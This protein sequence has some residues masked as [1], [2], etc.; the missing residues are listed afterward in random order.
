MDV[1]LPHIFNLESWSG[2]VNAATLIIAKNN[3]VIENNLGIDLCLTPKII[4]E[5]ENA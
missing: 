5:E 1:L 4:L 3:S 2:Y